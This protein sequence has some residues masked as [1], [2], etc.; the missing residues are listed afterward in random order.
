ME[1][2]RK[3]ISF[4]LAVIPL[5]IMITAMSFTIV[6]F[7]GAP[8]IP[9]ILGTVVSAFIAWRAGFK[10][11]EVEASIYKGIRLALPAVVI[12]I[13]VGVIIGAWIGG[14]IIA[15]MGYYGLMLISPE[16]FLMTMT[17]ISAIVALAIGSSWSTMGTI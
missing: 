5:I 1:K 8:H 12:I 16:V 17:I 10:W 14:G 15:T 4:G 9:L 13:I 3:P 2:E 7:E 11:K 6:V